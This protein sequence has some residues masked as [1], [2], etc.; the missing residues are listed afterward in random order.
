MPELP[1]VEVTRQGIFPHVYHH[2]I[3]R[4]IVR[5]ARLRWPVPEN[6]PAI[7]E[8]RTIQDVQRR[9]KYLL[10]P[11]DN[12][13]LIIHLGMSGCLRILPA[14]APVMKHDHVDLLLDSGNIL[15][16]TD[17]RRFGAM[18]WTKDDV[19]EHPLIQFLGPE[20]LS[21][22][23]TGEY[24]YSLSRNCKQAIKRFIM[25]N[26]RVV[27]VGNIYANEGLFY[28]GIR[29]TCLCGDISLSRYL[30]LEKAIRK[31]LSRAIEVG[32]TTLRNFVGG[33][34]KPSYFRIELAVY[35]RAGEACTTCGT[36][37]Q[38]IRLGNRSTYFCPLC[39]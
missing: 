36:V 28:A 27:G 13:T 11:T 35:G 8:R 21:S 23:F 20:P 6:L 2:R 39:Q 19:N 33:D 14:D 25:D 16:L 3:E 22:A 18:L 29:P 1:E 34:G 17:P 5:E 10:L 12:G 7:L 26:R 31:V 9:A 38:K 4:V 37:I 15:R 24:L 30:R 32:G